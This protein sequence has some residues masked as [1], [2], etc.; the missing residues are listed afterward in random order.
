MFQSK[1][2]VLLLGVV[3]SLLMIK[4]VSSSSIAPCSK[5]DPNT[6]IILDSTT[7]KLR[8]SCQFVRVND[9][10]LNEVK[11]GNVY[12]WM[13]VPYAEPPIGPLRFKRT[14]PKK[15]WTSEPLPLNATEW[16]NA[17]IQQDSADSA[18]KKEENDS[19]S[20]F[21]MW[22]PSSRHIKFSEDCLYLNI[23]TP[24]EAYL[25]INIQTPSATLQPLKS[26]IMVYFHGGGTVSG[27]SSLDIY[28]PST[29]VAATNTIV[30]T[31]NYRLGVFGFL[32]LDGEFPGNQALF[33][34]SEA[35]KWIKENAE[36][37]G[38]DSAKITLVGQ[39]AGASLVG[40]HLF[41]KE[42]WPLFRNMIL[43]SGT[44]L[45]TYTSP[46]SR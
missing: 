17:C 45:S 18:L 21:D 34:Q 33:D 44:P 46:I 4:R 38:G 11:S 41:F 16:P 5:N 37:F 22:T 9:N 2:V 19:F 15:P 24:A 12:S 27:S 8:G 39:S 10:N 28:D 42:S 43:Q 30:I 26:P 1:F 20:G 7:G 29:F 35:L 14:V 36:R 13:S 32:H 23:W 25:R 40:F 31:I 3:F 6:E